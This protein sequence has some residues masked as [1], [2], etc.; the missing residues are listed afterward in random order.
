M[1]VLGI[2]PVWWDEN[3]KPPCHT[4]IQ[5]GDLC[6]KGPVL[7]FITLRSRVK[8]KLKCILRKERC[9]GEIFLDL[10]S[11]FFFSS[12]EYKLKK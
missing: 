4:Q 5:W 7:A 6:G 10:F 2:S 1:V 3:K 12:E 9:R 11:P 8:I